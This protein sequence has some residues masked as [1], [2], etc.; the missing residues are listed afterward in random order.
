[1]AESG[2]ESGKAEIMFAQADG[3]IHA[4]QQA[5]L[6]YMYTGDVE[7]LRQ[8][9]LACGVRDGGRYAGCA[10]PNDGPQ[11]AYEIAYPAHMPA[12]ELRVIDPDGYVILVGQLQ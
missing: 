8:H 9:L 5:V 11:M 3:A 12:G 6:F 7:S 4:A 1:M 2:D 10:T